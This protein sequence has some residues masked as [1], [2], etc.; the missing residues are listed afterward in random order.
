MNLLTDIKE[1]VKNDKEH[2]IKIEVSSLGVRVLL[3]YDPDN[4]YEE[5]IIIPIE[6][7]TL[8]EFSYIPDSDYRKMFNINDYG[9]TVDEIDLISKIMHYLESHGREIQELCNGYA[10]EFRE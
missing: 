1:I 8:E 2:N 9:I 10:W 7:T 6:Y 5:K 3:D 4:N